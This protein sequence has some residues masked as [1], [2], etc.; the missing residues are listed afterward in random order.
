MPEAVL[1]PGI[2]NKNL[3]RITKFLQSHMEK[4]FG[5]STRV[6]DQCR[7]RRY[8]FHFLWRPCV[9]TRGEHRGGKVD[10][11]ILH[12]LQEVNST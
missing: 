6:V 9:K 7:L 12:V 4:E 8:P 11:V 3:T 2:R 5:N 1:L 10:A